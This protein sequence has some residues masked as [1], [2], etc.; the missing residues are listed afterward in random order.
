VN[1]VIAAVNA[2]I[3]ARNQQLAN[4]LKSL[5][6]IW[7]LNADSHKTVSTKLAFGLLHQPK[8]I[9]LR[10]APLTLEL[11]LVNDFTDVC[12]APYVHANSRFPEAITSAAWQ[13]SQVEVKCDV[14]T[15]DNALENSYEAHLLDKGTLPI[16]YNTYINQTQNISGQVDIAINVSRAISR[17][18]SIFINFSKKSAQNRDNLTRTDTGYD[19]GI[20]ASF[21]DINKPWNGF[22]H[23]MSGQIPK[24]ELYNPNL[25]FE[26]QIQI[27]SKQ[28]P[29]YPIKSIAE[30]FCQL[31][32]TMGYSGNCF[33]PF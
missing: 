32:K 6:L 4:N 27:G 20:L 33:D 30:T 1:G 29:E 5:G 11:E 13:I 2:K 23:P 3:T 19:N 12:V 14:C 22:Y 18:K 17:L 16:N 26:S 15:L 28:F 10:Y 7:K 25:E 31:R 24:Q 8:W 9:P 21:G